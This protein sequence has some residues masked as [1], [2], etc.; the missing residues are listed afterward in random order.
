VISRTHS[1]FS[2]TKSR[3]HVNRHLL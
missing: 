2:A 3:L 1:I